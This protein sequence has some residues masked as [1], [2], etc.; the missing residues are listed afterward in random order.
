[1]PRLVIEWDGFAW[2]PIGVAGNYA[3]AYPQIVRTGPA[4]AFPQAET[5]APL[6][7]KGT[8]RHRKPVQAG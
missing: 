1:M 7:R 3:E 8:G 4:E 2:Q 5:P 6:L